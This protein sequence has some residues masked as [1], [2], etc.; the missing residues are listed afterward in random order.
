M[1]LDKFIEIFNSRF[2][3]KMLDLATI[4]RDLAHMILISQDENEKQM[5]SLAPLR[6]FARDIVDM[7]E[8]TGGYLHMANFEAAYLQK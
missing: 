8:E 1:E 6:V 5:I 4:K 7:L 3:K 2:P